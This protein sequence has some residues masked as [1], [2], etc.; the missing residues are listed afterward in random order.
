M[1][2]LEAKAIVDV[3]VALRALPEAKANADGN[4]ALRALHHY[5]LQ[6]KLRLGIRIEIQRR[7]I[8]TLQ[9]ESHLHSHVEAMCTNYS[10]LFRR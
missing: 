10:G 6:Q 8:D 2:M 7:Y 4:V 5:F 3:D 9:F 1:W